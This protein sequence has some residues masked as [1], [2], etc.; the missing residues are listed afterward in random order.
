MSQQ[1]SIVKFKGK[2]D[3]ISFYEQGGRS[4]ARMA[5]GPSKERIMTDPAY[6]RTREHLAEFSG[7]AVAISTLLTA[8]LKVKIFRDKSLRARLSRTLRKVQKFDKGIR[9]QRKIEIS[10]HRQQLLGLRLNDG[11]KLES[12]FLGAPVTTHSADRNSATVTI[13]DVTSNDL[14]AV[15]REATHFR[16]VQFLAAVPDVVYDAAQKGY[17]PTVQGLSRASAVSFS[18]YYPVRGGRDINIALETALAL[19]G[20][21]VTD[22]TTVLQC[23]GIVFFENIDTEYYLIKDNATM[24][25]IDVF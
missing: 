18:G 3:G 21:A 17:Q 4:L 6:Q 25:V 8:T 13:N 7:L 23:L 15:P 1:I 20:T 14:S 11:Q 24:E 10:R 19:Q 22:T 5:K 9:G 16:I 12:V 2:M